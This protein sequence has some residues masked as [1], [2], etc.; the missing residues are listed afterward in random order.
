MR[1]LFAGSP[2]IAVPSL[3][4]VAGA[5]EL[6]G[7]LTNPESQKGRGL[8]SSATAV[9]I[10]AGGLAPSGAKASPSG[11]GVPILS[12]E[13]L[14][15]EARNAVAALEPDLLVSFAYGRIFG[16]KFLS[17][18]PRGGINVH[19]SLLPRWRGPTPIPA[20]ILHRDAESGVC[21]QRIAL[22]GAS[23][24]G[25]DEGDILAQERIVLDERETTASLS[26]KA[27]RIGAELVAEVVKAIAEG[28][29]S[30]RAQV[31]EASHSSL[32]AKDDGLIDWSAPVA[33]I[34][35]LVRAFDP[36][37][38]AFTHF[39]GLRLAIL[40]AV[41]YPGCG[42]LPPSTLAPGA[43]PSAAAGTILGLDKSLGLMVQ[44]IDG[45]V[46][47]RRLQLQQKKAL[48]WRDFA[49]GLRDLMGARLG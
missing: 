2:E 34:D 17:V 25:I 19:P 33:N 26:D 23:G 3:R 28:R 5:A 36:W 24:S 30:A 9:A 42:W 14:G 37:P 4:A 31:G 41:A 47:L 22:P 6:V 35:A 39:R 8:G 7:V 11:G 15:S 27:A 49:N 29:E 32:L 48:P 10:A 16:P 18:F 46:A 45:L 38:L 12:F 21:V 13:R 1:V 40:E 20:A 44:G 43:P